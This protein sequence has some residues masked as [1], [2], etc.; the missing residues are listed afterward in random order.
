MECLRLLITIS[1]HHQAPIH[2]SLVGHFMELL[3]MMLI[4]VLHCHLHLLIM[5]LDILLQDQLQ[6]VFLF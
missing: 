3:L 2:L 4:T 6:M 1:Q 5:E